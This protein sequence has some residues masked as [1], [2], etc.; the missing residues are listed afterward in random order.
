MAEKG[1]PRS[2]GPTNTPE[3]SHI[4]VNRPENDPKTRGTDFPSESQRGGHTE[5]GRKAETWFGAKLLT[6]ITTNGRDACTGKT[7]E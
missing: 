4:S 5:K 6:R 1:D 7:E 2:P 3:S